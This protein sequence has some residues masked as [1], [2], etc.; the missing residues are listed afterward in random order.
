MH[1]SASQTV[2]KQRF[3]TLSKE[4]HPDVHWATK[5]NCREMHQ[6]FAAVSQ[7]YA[8]LGDV[9]ARRDYDEKRTSSLFQQAGG[10]R[11][12]WAAA[13]PHYHGAHRPWAAEEDK[14]DPRIA[15]KFFN[16]PNVLF[17]GFALSLALGVGLQWLYL[18]FVDS[19]QERLARRRRST[20]EAVEMFDWEK[21]PVTVSAG[22]HPRGR[23]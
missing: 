7:A 18:S 12:E 11:A 15:K 20:K 5:E 3:I 13:Y 1:P 17:F 23:V 4:L 19:P 9:R 22:G 16:N 8:V 2:I 21:N 10:A 14:P 6:R